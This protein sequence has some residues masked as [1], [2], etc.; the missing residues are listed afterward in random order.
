[1]R[2]VDTLARFGGDEFLILLPETNSDSALAIAER[3]KLNA[4]QHLRERFGVSSVEGGVTLSMGV[5]AI[6]QGQ[7]SSAEAILARVDELLYSAKRAGKNRI[8]VG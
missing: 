5:V 7:D 2:E 8:S 3:V 1:M 4:R 6:Q